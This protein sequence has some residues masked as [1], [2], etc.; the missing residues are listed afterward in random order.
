MNQTSVKGSS[1][2]LQQFCHVRQGE[3]LHSVIDQIDTISRLLLKMYEADFVSVFYFNEAHRVMLP[4]AYQHWEDKTPTALEEL[5]KHWQSMPAV[6]ES[7]SR[8]E[9][10][11]DA[12]G[13]TAGGEE[14]VFAKANRFACRLQYPMY[15]HG[16]LRGVVLVYWHK[17]PSG[18]QKHPAYL[19]NAL[20]QVVLGA[21]SILEQIHAMDGFL[22]RLTSLIHLF[23]LPV[24]DV[25][26][27]EMLSGIV[28]AAR[29]LLPTSGVALITRDPDRE[30]C[31]LSEL[32]A[33]PAPGEAFLEDI[34][35]QCDRLLRKLSGKTTSD[36]QWHE[37]S[38]PEHDEYKS[39]IAIELS[40]ENKYHSAVVFFTSSPAGY[41][42]VDLE[43]ISIF[44]LFS[45][46]LLV[47]CV[48]VKD[49]KKT[50]AL[51]RESTGR[52]A[53]MESMAAIADMTSGIAHRLNN[54]IGGIT[55]RLQLMQVKNTDEALGAQLS[56]I[57]EMAM[58]GAHTVK[59]I[60]EFASCTRGGSLKPES[61]SSWL[62]T[63]RQREG[64]RWMKTAEQK[65]VKFRWEICED[66]AMI[67]ASTEELEVLLDHLI[68]NA[69][70]FAPEDSFVTVALT[71]DRY[72]F[73]L[74]VSD[75]GPG[76]PD[77]VLKKIFYPFFSTRQDRDA[78]MGLAI[79]HSIAVRHEGRV[80]VQSEAGVRTTL[81]IVFSRPDEIVDTSKVVKPQAKAGPRRILVVD[82]DQQLREV[83][84]DM[85]RLDGHEVTVACDGNDALERF[86]EAEFDL[87]ITDL[88]MPGMS[89]LDLAGVIHETNPDLPIAMITGWGTQLNEDEVALRGI[90]S[91]LSKPFHLRDIR[92]LVSELITVPE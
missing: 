37:L 80:E 39:V 45:Q 14:D 21:V 32:Q 47:N 7:V 90:R 62:S 75:T 49:L 88:G 76:I 59:R 87:V 5:E 20:I 11:L 12:E 63:M 8:G 70:D 3:K 73:A 30:K 84:S 74:S 40:P 55:G 33:V 6:E 85:L 92:S 27:Q 38:A 23:E 10:R 56:K 43:L 83:L 72:Q 29:Q 34:S 79:V 4:V 28:K 67:D 78:G 68:Q 82:D 71:A 26:I 46:I 54:V 36:R 1:R 69:V 57:E 24:V 66:R 52:L 44:R 15:A 50:N 89:G 31:R 22:L 19:L 58:E 16:V 25:R 81:S 2:Q 51:I 60:Q 77:M 18:A 42:Q 61:L 48:L 91:L 65:R 35:R 64:A 13:L 17:A 86:A 53:D 41:S 9:C